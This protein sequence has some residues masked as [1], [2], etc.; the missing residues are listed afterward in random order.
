[1]HNTILF[2]MF[3]IFFGAA[4]LASLALW[5]RQSL[6]VAYIVLG[7][8][9]GPGLGLIED[10]Q[11]IRDIGDIGI[12]FLLFL[13]GL[14]LEPQ[15]LVKM[16][17]QTTWITLSSS[18]IFCAV[19][20]AFGLINQLNLTDSI[21]IGT[22]MMFSSTIIGLKLLPTTVL[23]HQKM[24]ETVISILLLQDIIAIFALLFIEGAGSGGGLSLNEFLHVSLALPGLII[25]AFVLEK[26]VLV[27]ALKKFNR[28]HEYVFLLA[29]GWCLAL[30]EL[31]EYLKVSFEIGAFI[32]GISLAASPIS[33]FIAESLKPLRDFFLI[34]FFFSLGAGINL[35]Q[36]PSVILPAL[37]LAVLM[38]LIKPLSFKYLLLKITGS[39]SKSWETGVRIGQISEFSLLVVNK[40]IAVALISQKAAFII[41]LSTIITFMISSYW[42]L[43]RYHTPVSLNEKLRRD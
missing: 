28:I 14:N 4:L 20:I 18:L 19:G 43:N 35:E 10:Q 8:I 2:S 23:H 1:M 13:L 30:G 6:L 40:A 34:L 5:T 32:A 17:K 21:V 29:I 25:L 37:I 15:S 41:Q 42:I 36:L 16:L 24:G 22:C 12:I 31:A 9:V 27:P 26:W 38:I 3:L 39:E 7:A 11:A 33:R